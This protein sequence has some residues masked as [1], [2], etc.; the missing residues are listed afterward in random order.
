MDIT[1]DERKILDGVEKN[2][3]RRKIS[4]AA[5]IV[6]FVVSLG[7]SLFM[8][9]YIFTTAAKE[10]LGIHQMFMISPEQ[11]D[12]MAKHEILGKYSLSCLLWMFTN[13][14]VMMMLAALVTGLGILVLRYKLKQDR[15]TLKLRDRLK[16]LGEL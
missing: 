10:G 5:L 8:G 12:Q 16:E 11:I 2:Y 13:E 9:Y 15:V 3:R 1:A 4:L 14:G 6:S 7:C